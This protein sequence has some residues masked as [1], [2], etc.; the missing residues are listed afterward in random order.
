[1]T[2]LTHNPGPGAKYCPLCLTDSFTRRIRNEGSA[3]D[4][5]SFATCGHCGEE[6]PAADWMTW[7]QAREVAA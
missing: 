1:M 3:T 5:H 2:D 6:T 7:N 4:M